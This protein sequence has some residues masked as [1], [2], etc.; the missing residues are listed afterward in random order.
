M[1]L[2]KATAIM[3][4][5]MSLCTCCAA[6]KTGLDN[7]ASCER[8]FRGKRVGIITNH[9][10]C[11]SAG[12]H[13]TDVFGDME[14]VRVTALF[15][16]EHGIR[17]TEAAGKKID[18]RTGEAQDV[19]IYSLYGKTTKPTPEMLRDVD[20]L[21]FDIQDVGA[22]F[23]T[24]TYTMSLAMEAA[25]ENGKRFVVL[26]RPNPINGLAVEGNILEPKFASFVGLYPIP[27]R[28]GM[29]VGELAKM[30]NEQG[31]LK[32][33][34]KADLVVVPMQG[35]RRGLWYD[36]TGLRFIK[37]SPN[38]TNLKTATVY[39][40]PCLL[41]G[42]NVSEGRGT[43]KPFLQFGAPWIDAGNLAARLNKL[44]LPGIR[45]QPTNY[46]PNASKYAG[47]RCHGAEITITNRDLLESY[48]A[49]IVVVNEIRRM[50]P[51]D[52]EWRAGHFDRL[53]GTADVR[54][55]IANGSSLQRLR[56]SWQARLK[57]FLQIRKRYL[58]YAK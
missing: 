17:G 13:I 52:F 40:G 34:V 48:W 29:T 27:V 53:C 18:S 55:A 23:Y 26:D 38:M 19:P 20:V 1:R 47:E 31:W 43:S 54:N 14:G 2:A 49:G 50:Y 32:G 44:N 36:Q 57:A 3:V 11:N 58:L 37:P 15:G 41:E 25:A 6:V 22:R 39:P 46:T 45:F 5:A 21:V 51:D 24:Y 56:E 9:T 42:T 16:P 33:G 10:A 30:F 8:V 4:L 7:I 12:R 28:H 35:W